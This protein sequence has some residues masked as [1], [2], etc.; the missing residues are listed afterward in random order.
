MV[1][2]GGRSRA[3]MASRQAVSSA[4]L[5][6]KNGSSAAKLVVYS[7]AN[8]LTPGNRRTSTAIGLGEGDDGAIRRHEPSLSQRVLGSVKVVG[9]G[10][11]AWPGVG[12]GAVV[13]ARLIRSIMLKNSAL[14]CYSANPIGGTTPLTHED[15]SA[16]PALGAFGPYRVMHQIGV[17]VLGPVFRTYH[18]GRRSVGG[19]QGLSP[20]HDAGTGRHS[21]AAALNGIVQAGVVH[22]SLVTPLGAGLSEGVAYLAMEYVVAESLD[23]A[24][25]QLRAGGGRDGAPVR[26]AAGR[27]RS[28]PHM[29]GGC[30]TVRCTC[31]TSS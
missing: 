12:V 16:F 5:P 31:A 19:A 6:A 28:I 4:G 23:V 30:P 8:R 22:P 3:A 27:R 9:P 13:R 15:S 21:L 17:G 2:P 25:R 10:E 26:G 7:A 14:P 11:P 20:R 24:I 18:P 29:R 1:V